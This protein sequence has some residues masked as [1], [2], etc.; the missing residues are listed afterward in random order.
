MACVVDT[1]GWIEWLTY[2]ALASKFETWLEN[3][4]NLYVPTVVQ[5]ELY[6][7]VKH[8]YGETRA[9]EVAAQTEQGNVV[10]LRTAISLL[11]T[12]I[13]LQHGLSSLMQSSTLQHSTRMRCW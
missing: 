6:R 5:F 12:D 4:A 9:L 11:A 13:V 10:P 3:L 2:G 7:C 1:C 8:E